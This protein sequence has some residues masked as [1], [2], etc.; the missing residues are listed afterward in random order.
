MIFT[1]C[2]PGWMLWMTSWPRDFA[3]TRSMKSR[4]TLKLTSASRSAMRTSRRDSATFSSE[5]LPK[6]RKFLNAVWSLVLNVSNMA[7]KYV[8][9]V[10][11]AKETNG[12]GLTTVIQRATPAPANGVLDANDG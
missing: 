11:R 10:G 7:I 4:A 2:W 1:I 8:A 12:G 5:I 6:P 9:W 3:L